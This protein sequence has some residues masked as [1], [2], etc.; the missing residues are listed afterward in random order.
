MFEEPERKL[1]A[2]GGTFTH[3]AV[4]HS[5]SFRSMV[6]STSLTQNLF[7]PSSSRERTKCEAIALNVLAPFTLSELKKD[8]NSNELLT[9]YFNARKPKSTKIVA[10]LVGYCSTTDGHRT[11]VLNFEEVR[12]ETSDILSIYI[13]DTFYANRLSLYPG[14]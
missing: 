14:L 12:G 9:V 1:L 4:C 13:L 10:I 11:R 2:A 3:H 8:L 5:M 7:K 6:C